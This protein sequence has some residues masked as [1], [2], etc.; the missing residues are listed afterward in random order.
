[1]IGTVTASWLNVRGQPSPRGRRP[2]ALERGSLVDVLGDRGGWLEI[3]FRGAPAFLA[4]DH[5]AVAER[6]PARIGVVR[7]S[8]LSA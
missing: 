6:P 4:R 8:L 1:M 7:A 2:G 5:V 3:E